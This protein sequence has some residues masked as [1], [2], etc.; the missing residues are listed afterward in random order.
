MIMFQ[1]YLDIVGKSRLFHNIDR[2]TIPEILQ[3]LSGEFVSFKKGQ[4]LL[5]EHTSTDKLGII[6]SGSADATHLTLDGR[7]ITAAHLNPSSVYGDA[8]AANKG[9]LSPVTVTALENN[10]AVLLIPYEKIFEYENS[11][12]FRNLTSLLADKYFEQ[13][14]RIDLM[15]CPDL[16]S[17]ILN[18]LL[19]FD[20]AKAGRVFD[21]PFN[22]EQLAEYLNANRS[23][24]SRE[25][26]RMKAEGIIDYHGNSFKLMKSAF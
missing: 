25:L 7:R 22:R 1:K 9:T 4:V 11:I 14:R 21:V 13:H 6:L 16:R 2:I 3:K 17:K 23:A 26:S 12:L 24:L 19:S 20:D 15:L 10:T 5:R 18:Y 8:L